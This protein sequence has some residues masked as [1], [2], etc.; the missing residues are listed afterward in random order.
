MTVIQGVNPFYVAFVLAPLASNA[1]E[2][3]A[4]VNYASKKTPKSISISIATLEGAAC[5]NNT[6]GLAIFMFLVYYQGLA[7][8]YL[9]ETAV[10]LLVQV[11][12]IGARPSWFLRNYSLHILCM[13]CFIFM[14]MWCIVMCSWQSESSP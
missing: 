4:S 11:F 13:F 9:A 7:W 6:F 1:S 3:I 14:S 5:M 2:L 10:I 8:Q 12:L